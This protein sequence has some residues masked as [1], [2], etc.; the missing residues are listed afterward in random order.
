MFSDGR[1]RGGSHYL[2]KDVLPILYTAGGVIGPA[3]FALMSPFTTG[4]GPKQAM[5]EAVITEKMPVVRRSRM[6]ISLMIDA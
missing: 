3:S 2:Y 5:K 6:A 4:R 1:G